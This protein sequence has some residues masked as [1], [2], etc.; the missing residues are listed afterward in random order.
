V[1]APPPPPGWYPDGQGGTRWWDGQRWTEQAQRGTPGANDGLRP[2]IAAAAAKM[3]TKI[4]G[5]REIKRL[6]EHLWEGES[7]RLIVSGQYGNGIGILVATDRRLFFLK[8]GVM[9]KTSED[10][11]YSKVTS[12]QW[13]SGM[14]MGT[15]TIFASGNKAEIKNVD[16]VGGKDIVDN[17]RGLLAQASAA[18]SAPQPPPVA[19]RSTDQL[20]QLV[21]MH[22]SGALTDEEFTAAKARQLGL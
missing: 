2:D 21:Q 11:P 8:D 19:A 16:K 17:V 4:G 18:P 13:S 15:I 10:F 20:A 12:I 6:V 22:R 7:V 1:T 14:L 9:S 5:K 3:R